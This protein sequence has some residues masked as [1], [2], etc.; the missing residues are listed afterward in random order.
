LRRT[1][2]VSGYGAEAPPAARWKPSQS[3]PI[4]PPT[5]A[6]TAGLPVGASLVG[7]K[8]TD[9][10]RCLPWPVRDQGQRGTCVAFGTAAL[11]E[12]L[13]CE[14]AN[15]LRDVCEQFLYWDIKTNSPDPQKSTDGTWI[16][17]AFESLGRAGICP[18]ATWPYNPVLNS[19][20]ISQGGPGAPPVGAASQAALWAVPAS[21]YHTVSATSGN[22]QLVL[23]ALVKNGLPVAISLPVFSD[24]LLPQADN[25]STSAGWL[26]GNV[27]DPPPTSI[28]VGGHC[29]CVTGF[30]PDAAEPLGGYFVIRNSWSTQWGAQLPLAGHHGPEAGY[31]Q[32]SATYVD[33]FLWEYGQF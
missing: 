27:L 4:P 23:D 1:A 30:Q 16:E 2:T 24:P 26:F 31:G 14:Q 28:V 19:A 10:R 25:W 9:L 21:L 17:F 8:Q 33:K 12:L 7:A 32:V 29:V 5:R 22:A 3:V 13:M 18:E 15:S 6:S 11:R 20:N